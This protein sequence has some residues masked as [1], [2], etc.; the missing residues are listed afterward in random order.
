MNRA[1]LFLCL[2]D[3]GKRGHHTEETTYHPEATNCHP[4]LD[5]GSDSVTATSSNQLHQ[6]PEHRSHDSTWRRSRKQADPET[7][8]G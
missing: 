1:A 5:S 4:E 7:S 2:H 3:G 6:I 8:S